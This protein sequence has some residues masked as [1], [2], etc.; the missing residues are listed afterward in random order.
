MQPVRFCTKLV[1]DSRACPSV[2]SQSVPNCELWRA[3]ILTR[4]IIHKLCKKFLR[5]IIHQSSISIIILEN[6]AKQNRIHFVAI[7]RECKNLKGKLWIIQHPKTFIHMQTFKLISCTRRHQC[8]YCVV[9][10]VSLQPNKAGSWGGIKNVSFPSS[11]APNFSVYTLVNCPT[12]WPLSLIFGFRWWSF[13]LV[14]KL[15]QRWEK[16]WPSK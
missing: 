15:K 3:K 5:Q 8:A 14:V 2:N 10:G 11:L 16:L 4:Q 9:I 12:G 6:C 13:E 1:P 7:F